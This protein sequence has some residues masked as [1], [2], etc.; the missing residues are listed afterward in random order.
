MPPGN[1]LRDSA[2]SQIRVVSDTPAL[3]PIPL[4]IKFHPSG[5]AIR[6]TIANPVAAKKAY[7]I[8]DEERLYCW[9]N[10]HPVIAMVTTTTTVSSAVAIERTDNR[11]LDTSVDLVIGR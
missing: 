6:Y 4:T 7:D 2:S 5:L 10:F 3:W 8:N 9:F 1:H 11:E